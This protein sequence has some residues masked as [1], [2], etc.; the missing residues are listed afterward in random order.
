[1]KQASEFLNMRE[2]VVFQTGILLRRVASQMIKATHTADAD[3][4]HDLRVTIRRLSRCL[5]VFAQF[6]PGGARKQL[7]RRLADLLSVC[8]GVRDRDIAIGLL[9]KAGVAAN[10]PLVRRLGAERRAGGRELQLELQR[11]K[12]RGFTRRWRNQLEL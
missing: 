2:Y 4:V 5:R 11:W 12:P 6:Y 1:V 10:S 9:R 3:A 7:R 8:G